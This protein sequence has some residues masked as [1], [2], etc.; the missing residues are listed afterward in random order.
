M[1]TSNLQHEAPPK[2]NILLVDDEPANLLALETILGELGQT[3]IQ[4]HSGEEAL[5]NILDTDFAVVL[6]DV[7]MKGIDG[8]ET[9]RLI[10]GW[11]RSRHTPIIFLTAYDTDRLKVD[12]AYALGA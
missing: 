8:L 12:E 5:Q 6:L 1:D 10:R 9:A 4:A 2:V 7:Q 3:L 11:S